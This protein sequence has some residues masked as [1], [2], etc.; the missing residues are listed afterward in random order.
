MVQITSSESG[1]HIVAGAGEL[2][3]EICL[4]DL[5]EDFMKGAP[6]SISPP[7]V[8]FRETVTGESSQICLSKSANK[9]NRVFAQAEPL[10]EGMAEAVDEG[11]VVVIKDFKEKAK[12][13]NENFGLPVEEGRK[14][15]AFGP[16]GTGPNIITDAT[17]AVQYLN[18]VK[19]S[20]VS[21]FQW[22]TRAGP[23]ADEP[24][25]AVKFKVLDVTLH[26]D[27]IHRGMGQIMP[28][29]R[30]VCYASL[31]TADPNFLEPIFLADISVPL[32]SSGGIYGVLSAR[33]GHVF[34]E[35]PRVGTPI[36]QLKAYLP[37][38]ESFGFTTDLRA[39]TGG[40]AFPQCAFSH[41]AVFT[42]GDPL[43][44]GTPGNALVNSIRER[45]GLEPGVPPLDRFHD[46]L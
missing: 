33:R 4:K 12:F 43:T 9:H 34:A 20:I 31:L 45:K 26:A 23:M 13:L 11:K 21:G 6:I 22:A 36:T 5:Q 18:E 40:K 10:P 32:D 25:R 24:M 17:T 37:V 3:L 35:E 28:T 14:I 46:R 38:A 27:S 8:S 7:V 44:E 2:H 1:E 30:K 19:E 29:A 42:G 39:A 16:D 41:W 15:W